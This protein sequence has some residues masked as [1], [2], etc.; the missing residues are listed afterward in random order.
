MEP[1]EA[2]YLRTLRANPVLKASGGTCKDGFN[3]HD[4][5]MAAGQ[6]AK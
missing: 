5:M 6:E 4:E 1:E 3:L 2:V